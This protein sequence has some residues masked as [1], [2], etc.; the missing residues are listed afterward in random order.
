MV[1]S[2]MLYSI[3]ALHQALYVFVLVDV[4][5]LI[6]LLIETLKLGVLYNMNIKGLLVIDVRS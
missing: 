1:T 6:F 5:S 2:N 4:L 3:I